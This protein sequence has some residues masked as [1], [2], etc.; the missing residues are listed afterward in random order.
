M[1]PVAGKRSGI[2]TVRRDRLRHDVCY[3]TGMPIQVASN[4]TQET[5][6]MMMAAQ[7]KI[8]EAEAKAILAEAK[9][10]RGDAIQLLAERGHIT[11]EQV[12]EK[13]RW[14]AA[15]LLVKTIAWTRGDYSFRS[16]SSPRLP[17]PTVELNFPKLL[18]KGL[19]R[20]DQ[21][22]AIL[23][24]VSARTHEQMALGLSAVLEA[25]R[26]ALEDGDSEFIL[27]INGTLAVSDLLA[28]AKIPADR[29]TLMLWLMMSCGSVV[30]ADPSEAGAPAPA[31]VPLEPPPPVEETPPEEPEELEEPAAREPIAVPFDG[32]VS[33]EPI[34]VPF[35]GPVPSEPIAPPAPEV[36]PEAEELTERELRRRRR[37]ERIKARSGGD[38][39]ASLF[40]DRE[41]PPTPSGSTLGVGVIPGPPED[42]SDLAPPTL[43]P[44]SG[45]STPVGMGQI[46]KPPDD[47]DL[48]APPTLS[49]TSGS[50]PP[51]GPSPP[52]GVGQIPKPPDDDDLLAPPT[53][54]RSGEFPVATPAATASVT[55]DAA[56]AVQAPAA[57]LRSVLRE[58]TAQNY[59]EMLGLDHK[60]SEV[61]IRK[62]YHALAK[63]YH[64]D[65]FNDQPTEVRDGA[66]A[67][68]AKLSEAHQTLSSKTKRKEYIDHKIHGKLTEEE[69]AMEKVRKIMD[70]EQSFK[71]GRRLLNAGQIVEAR[72]HFRRAHEGYEDDVEYKCY[73]GYLTY[74]LLWQRDP[75]EAAD[76]ER[77][78]DSVLN[79]ND[80][81]PVANYLKGMIEAIQG[82]NRLAQELLKKSLRAEPDNDDARRELKRIQRVEL[83]GGA[84]AQRKGK[85]KTAVPF[86]GLFDR[87]KKKK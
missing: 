55:P 49:S 35:D 3:L 7:K 20:V 59:F 27:G 54:T 40:G 21:R 75:L 8:V 25:N 44:T 73:Y 38:L 47:D 68:F 41:E 42:D 87:F 66:E 12:E 15:V 84:S 23:A 1:M 85:G 31:A 14:H 4:A 28:R 33:S 32:P 36:E 2:L 80:K 82:H 37:R 18:I 34:A 6:P 50:S 13:R 43:S 51:A 61:D 24:R 9:A 71:I 57:E 16:L 76:G 58:M 30:P 53:L 60:A 5:L 11:A 48:L 70:A 69:K 22:D 46:P 72:E 62:A 67:V 56:A 64:P 74:K 10:S 77:L 17:G 52:P 86:A 45:S 39:G 19:R 26:F 65:R 63:R 78:V 79:E 81:H 83:S 29:A